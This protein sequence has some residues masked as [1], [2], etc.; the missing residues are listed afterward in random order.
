MLPKFCTQDGHFIHLVLVPAL[1]TRLSGCSDRFSQHV[2]NKILLSDYC[3]PISMLNFL[4]EM[5]SK[6]GPKFYSHGA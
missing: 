6:N 1:E 2:A 4:N 5:V 3:M